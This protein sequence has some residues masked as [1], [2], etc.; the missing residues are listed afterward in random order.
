MFAL[1]ALFTLFAGGVAI[2]SKGGGDALAFPEPDDLEP[3]ALEPEPEPEPETEPSAADL[4]PMAQ[5][6]NVVQL[7][8]PG[9]FREVR[10]VLEGGR[11][12]PSTVYLGY[13][14]DWQ[15]RLQT[16][17]V[18]RELAAAHPDVRFALFDFARSRE[19]FGLPD[20]YLAFVS[21]ASD[22]DGRAFGQ[23]F[24]ADR[25][26]APALSR[27]RIARLMRNALEGPA[28]QVPPSSRNPSGF[29]V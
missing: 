9:D 11:G 17:V 12:E 26:N 14:Q 20:E 28:S 21:T 7:E 2:A 22:P 24:S 4:E 19:L 16:L 25:R 1:F 13:A 8:A 15:G 5:L 6:M 3:L 10:N 27:A 29:S 18:V 23:T